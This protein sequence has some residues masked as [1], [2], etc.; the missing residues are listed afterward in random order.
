[1]HQI[2][3]LKIG[4]CDLETVMKASGSKPYDLPIELKAQAFFQAWQSK[5]C[6]RIK[7]TDGGFF[8][9]YIEAS[10]ELSIFVPDLCSAIR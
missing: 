6:N 2:I 9:P 1:M 5:E 3:T 8:K 4:L 7:G 10:D